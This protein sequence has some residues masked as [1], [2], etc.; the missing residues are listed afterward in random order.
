MNGRLHSNNF[1]RRRLAQPPCNLQSGSHIQGSLA[2]VRGGEGGPSDALLFFSGVWGGGESPAS[3]PHA[4]AATRFPASPAAEPGERLSSPRAHEQ[5]RQLPPSLQTMDQLLHR[6][7]VGLP[8]PNSEPRRQA[9]RWKSQLGQGVSIVAPLLILVVCGVPFP[10]GGGHGGAPGIPPPRPFS[11]CLHWAA[12]LSEARSAR[13]GWGEGAALAT[14]QDDGE[15]LLQLPRLRHRQLERHIVRPEVRL[16]R[17]HA[18]RIAHGGGPSA[19]KG[20]AESRP[21]PRLALSL[22]REL[23]QAARRPPHSARVAGS[24]IPPRAHPPA[25]RLAPR[26]RHQRRN[27]AAEPGGMHRSMSPSST[28]R[29]NER[30]PPSCSPLAAASSSSSPAQSGSPPGDAGSQ[31][32]LHVARCPPR[33]VPPGRSMVRD[34]RSAAVASGCSERRGPFH[35]ARR[36]QSA[37]RR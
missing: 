21:P 36:P 7:L 16:L 9:P 26:R 33:A 18:A 31:R 11:V 15:P 22:A 17:V 4:L 28:G 8:S 14:H 35:G 37:A 6:Q 19:A 1:N 20:A 10:G 12:W 25:D 13:P 29:G 2:G 27:W 34:E 24:V 23:S 5:P 30:L 3:E 32:L